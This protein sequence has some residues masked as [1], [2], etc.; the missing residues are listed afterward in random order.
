LWNPLPKGLWVF[1]NSRYFTASENILFLHLLSVN[2]ALV[3]DEAAADDA[4]A[5]ARIWALAFND[6]FN[7]LR[8]GSMTL[9]DK[10]TL[11]TKHVLKYM[12][13]K[14]AQ[15]YVMRDNEAGGKVAA[16]ATWRSP[17]NKQDE[18]WDQE[19]EVNDEQR[20]QKR[21]SMEEHYRNNFSPFTEKV[22]IPLIAESIEM[23][24][25]LRKRTLK[26]RP[27]FG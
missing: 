20:L 2:M 25:R 6:P 19:E 3:L 12:E 26:G 4:P 17:K 22:N 1:I 23:W 15:W 9:D 7:S 18:N 5:I 13:D 8:Y 10:I 14:E 24:A 11:F 16:F 27:A 21:K